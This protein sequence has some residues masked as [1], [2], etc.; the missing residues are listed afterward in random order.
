MRLCVILIVSLF[1]ALAVAGETKPFQ[2]D[3]V[4]AQQ[5][6]L[7]ADVV[8]REGRYADM[9]SSKRSELLAKQDRLFV[10]LEGKQSST[11][12]SNDQYLEAFSTLEWIEATVNNADDERMICTRE[13]T[14]GSNRATR[15]CRSAAQME[16]Q[17]ESARQQ[18][19]SN[20]V[21]GGN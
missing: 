15:V 17:R 10:M 21:R 8:A 12:L 16:A 14:L 13:K 9:P 11:D 19:E 20:T 1:S 4:L 6:R 18:M 2:V 7:R 5:Q 3:E